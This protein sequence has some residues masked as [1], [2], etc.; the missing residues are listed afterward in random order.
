ML[1]IA[2]R[3]GATLR[4]VGAAS[5]RRFRL[6][7]YERSAPMPTAKPQA[8]SCAFGKLFHFLWKFPRQQL[9][10]WDR[11]HVWHPFTPM[12]TYGTIHPY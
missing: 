10:Q 12:Q 8:V 3:P 2:G 11:E 9:E 7:V 4:T 6:K 5:A 1:E